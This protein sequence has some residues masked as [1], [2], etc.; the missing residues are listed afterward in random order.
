MTS[1]DHTSPAAPALDDIA[2]DQHRDITVQ[3]E[4]QQ[5]QALEDAI[6]YRRARVSA[7]CPDCT[8]SGQKGD[9]HA[10]DLN[11]IAVYQ[12][13]AISVLNASSQTDAIRGNHLASLRDETSAPSPASPEPPCQRLRPPHRQMENAGAGNPTCGVARL[14][15]HR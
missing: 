1:G 11:L 12:R 7:L 8:A 14:S 13:T 2:R 10:C 6:A 9:D 5:L 3:A 15:S 4:C